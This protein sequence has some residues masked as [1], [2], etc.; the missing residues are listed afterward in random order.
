[1]QAQLWP[2]LKVNL[3]DMEVLLGEEEVECEAGVVINM[4]CHGTNTEIHYSPRMRSDLSPQELRDGVLPIEACA[5]TRMIR[6]IRAAI[7]EEVEEGTHLEVMVEE[8]LA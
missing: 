4:I 5:S 8:G 1:M 2:D 3:I 6:S 7:E